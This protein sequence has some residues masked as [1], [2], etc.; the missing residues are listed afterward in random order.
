[1]SKKRTGNSK[2]KNMEILRRLEKQQACLFKD[3]KHTCD[4]NKKNKLTIG[5]H[6][7]S[8]KD[9][10]S[11]IASKDDKVLVF[12]IRH[13]SYYEKEERGKL[14]DLL[15]PVHISNT[16]NTRNILCGKHDK[17]LFDK[18]EN[19]IKLDENGANYKQQCFQFA[20]RAFIFDYIHEKNVN[21]KEIKTGHSELANNRA[22]IGLLR[23]EKILK[24]F[25]EAYLNSNWDC[26]E[27]KV[28]TLDKRANFISCLS[29]F[30]MT[31]LKFRYSGHVSD[32]IYLNIFPENNQTK[33]VI[34]YFVNSSK[35]CKRLSDIIYSLYLKKNFK[36]IE[37]FLTRCV[38]LYDLKV[39]YNIDYFNR[40]I[41]DET[42]KMQFIKFSLYIR[43]ARNF[44][45]IYNKNFLRIFV[46]E[47][48]RINLFDDYL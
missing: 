7:I 29:F 46:F 3:I 11:R 33:I 9:Y 30:P 45:D 14:E 41:H 39:T 10:L 43:K 16:A 42:R 27:T 32:K 12:N 18:I 48:L 47:K 36:K 2:Y 19:G 35:H 21:D 6:I 24:K 25:Q 8:E 5:S 22:S 1:M 26:I 38:L 15:A 23:S 4:G 28:I 17:S 31:Y 40:L 44:S 13:E 20:L 34:S 37:E